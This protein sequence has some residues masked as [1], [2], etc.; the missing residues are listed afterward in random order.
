MQTR[1][2]K[3]DYTRNLTKKFNIQVLPMLIQGVGNEATF[4]SQLQYSHGLYQSIFKSENWWYQL[5]A[6][7]SYL[8]GAKMRADD[9]PNVK[10]VYFQMPYTFTANIMTDYY[11]QN[12][13]RTLVVLQKIK[14]NTVWGTN[15]GSN[16]VAIHTNMNVI[17][18]A[19]QTTCVDICSY[20]S[21]VDVSDITRVP[22]QSVLYFVVPIM[23]Q[24]C[25]AC[26][27]G[28]N[29]ESNLSM[30]TSH[31]LEELVVSEA[32]GDN[33]D[34]T[35]LEVADLCAVNDFSYFIHT[36]FQRKNLVGS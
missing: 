17:N 14:I 30:T 9:A 5:N 26:S 25:T 11:V 16:I 33:Q 15:W 7:S 4:E 24:S 32:L 27:G 2:G 36:H 12:W 6:Y 23:S 29:D 1:P 21:S 10:F 22:N 34:Y 19:S 13:I 3:N 20:H 35:K 18:S 28:Y 31:E 8:R